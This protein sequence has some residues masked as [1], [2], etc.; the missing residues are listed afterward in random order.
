M[1]NGLFSPCSD[2]LTSFMSQK[3]IRTLQIYISL[4]VLASSYFLNHIKHISQNGNF[5]RVTILWNGLFSPCS[6]NLTSFMSQK[7]IR[8][9]Q[10]YISLKVLASSY[11]L[12]HIKHISQNGNFRS[13][14]FLPLIT[15]SLFLG[16]K[17]T[18][19]HFIL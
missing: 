19:K 5:R 4:E 9:L 17:N 1:W 2:N 12:N 15:M 8:T 14:Y 6:D 3:Y 7:Y 16:H 11:F 18:L 13:Y 10:I